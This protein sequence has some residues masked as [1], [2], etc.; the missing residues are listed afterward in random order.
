MRLLG[1]Q[2]PTDSH[3]PMPSAAERAI[4]SG[5]PA[6]PE[7]LQFAKWLS[8]NASDTADRFQHQA[9]AFQKTSSNAVDSFATQIQGMVKKIQAFIK[10][11]RKYSTPD[12]IKILEKKVEDFAV[13]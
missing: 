12:G 1:G 3:G 6:R 8:W 2:A 11:M 7:T 9:F 13:N 5:V 10:M 4:N